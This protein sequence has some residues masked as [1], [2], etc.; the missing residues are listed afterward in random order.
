MSDSP[1][2]TVLGASG[3]GRA[4]VAYL[5]SRGIK[6]V[7]WN[8]GFSRL[9]PV[10]RAGG[11][12]AKGELEG[13]HPVRLATNDIAKAVEGA[14][15]IM[16]VTP[17]FAHA[18]LARKLAPH[19]LP[20]QL[21]LLNPGRTYGAVEFRRE[22]ER[23]RGECPAVVAEAQ[24]LAFTSR[25]TG[26]AG[27]KI[28]R[29]KDQ[30]KYSTF[31]EE[32]L[33][34][35]VPAIEE[36]FPQFQPVEEYLET[37]LNNVGVLVHPTT[38]ILNAA[39]IDAGRRFKFYHE[40]VTPCV[41]RLMRQVQDEVGRVFSAL[42]L[43]Q[44]TLEHWAEECYGVSFGYGEVP[45]DR[46]LNANPA[47]ATIDAPGSL[48]TRYLREDV[49]Y[50]LVPLWSTAKH[51]GVKVPTVRALVWLASVISGLDLARAGRRVG[52][53]GLKR[54]LD[55]KVRECQ[56]LVVGGA[57]DDFNDEFDDSEGSFDGGDW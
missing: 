38:T 4:M 11:V 16:V 47:Y 2:V 51:L 21:V 22:V 17:A 1:N 20:G 12:F 29:V 33:P 24:T 25:A 57:L 55:G 46:V 30:V 45:L 37:T 3:G 50:G 54:F 10:K 36:I 56:K 53:L 31:P 19:L 18:E 41:G 6:P 26:G 15:A 5:S 9:E 35:I 14:D 13:F 7:V 39:S 8:R 49:P 44:L 42:G 32:D 34:S 28:Y 23:G 43:N 48:E 27:V 52:K 40:G